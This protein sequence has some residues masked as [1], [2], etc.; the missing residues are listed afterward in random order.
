MT[1]AVLAMPARRGR[2]QERDGRERFNLLPS[3]KRGEGRY[4]YALGLVDGRTKIGIAYRPRARV[5]AHW[6]A[7]RGGVT[8]V[9]VFG[10]FDSRAVEKIERAACSL[11]GQRSIRIGRTETFLELERD[12]A[13]RSVR[14]AVSA[15]GS[16]QPAA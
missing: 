4:L 16:P 9:H 12:E 5:V 14:E 2:K 10:R 6:V 7:T 8:W 3:G 13:L 1:A 11:A 15:F